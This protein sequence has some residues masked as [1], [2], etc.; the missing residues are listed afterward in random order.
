MRGTA[1]LIAAFLKRTASISLGE[2]ATIENV[3]CVRDFVRA[4]DARTSDYTVLNL[5]YRTAQAERPGALVRTEAEKLLGSLG[6]GAGDVVGRQS[7]RP[8]RR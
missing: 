1:S 5:V 7:G 4:A 2:V 6:Q 8:G 3:C